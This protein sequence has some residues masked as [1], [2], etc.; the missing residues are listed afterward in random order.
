[1]AGE[2]SFGRRE[3]LVLAGSAAAGSAYLIRNS[4]PEFSIELAVTEDLADLSEEETGNRDYVLDLME[5]FIDNSVRPFA[6]G[7]MDVS[8]EYSD[9]EPNV[10]GDAEEA[11]KE[12][13]SVFDDDKCCSLLVTGESYDGPVGV[14]EEVDD[15]LESSAALVGEG[16][17]FMDLNEDEWRE[18]VQFIDYEVLD[19]ELNY[20]PWKTVVAAI[21]EIGH[22]MGLEHTDGEVYEVEDGVLASVMA[23]SYSGEIEDDLRYSDDIY[24]ST[25]FSGSSRE[26]LS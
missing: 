19:R 11:L 24:W 26:K 21:H 22:T 1:M 20:T 10:E 12:W 7:L 3:F 8:V 15:P 6:S 18:E 16:Y 14:A 9:L 25:R 13:R 5:S 17:D 23:A 2:R 4:R